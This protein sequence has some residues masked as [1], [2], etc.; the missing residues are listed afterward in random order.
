MAA[1]SR[2][3]RRPDGRA[4]SPPLTASPLL[5]RNLQLLPVGLTQLPNDETFVNRLRQDIEALSSAFA[6]ALLLTI[7]AKA[8]AASL[9]DSTGSTSSS[10][11]GPSLNIPS[12]EGFAVS[13]FSVFVHIWREKGW[14]YVQF[15]FGDHT[16]SKRA[17][18]DAICRV[19]LEGLEPYVTARNRSHAQDPELP[20][21][22]KL[23]NLKDMFKT[24]AIPFALYLFWSTQIHPTSGIGV[25]HC[26]PALERIPIEQDYYD[27]LL[28]LPEVILRHLREE[29]RTKNLSDALTADL[30]EVLCRLVGEPSRNDSHFEA[31][32]PPSLAPSA[33][34]VGKKRRQPWQDD[35]SAE[36]GTA[37]NDSDPVF[38]IIPSSSL[39][40]RL[41]RIWPSVRVMSSQE[42]NKEFGRIG[43]I[44]RISPKD[45]SAT[46]ASGNVDSSSAA[47]GTREA[48]VGLSRGDVVRLKAKQRLAKA[49]MDLS[50]ILDQDNQSAGATHHSSSSEGSAATHPL[51]LA[52]ASTSEE[53]PA[54]PVRY[55]IDTPS[56]IK[57][58]KYTAKMQPWLEQ[59][60]TPIQPSLQRIFKN[61]Q[62]YSEVREKIM[63]SNAPIDDA[64]AAEMA[65][66]HESGT[67][68]GKWILQ[69]FRET[70]KEMQANTEGSTQEDVSGLPNVDDQGTL[71]LDALYRLAAERT[72][73]I[74]VERGEML[75]SARAN[76]SRPG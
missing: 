43:T 2:K 73:T 69:R 3:R 45:G 12:T 44:V 28:D 5:T 34:A 57:S 64:A 68:Y 9:A 11:V 49:N 58:A 27:L 8:N 60:S 10:S 19:L 6:E 72:K 35:V 66:G 18:S 54:Q 65:D 13:P 16:D 46:E 62:R 21:Q 38:D 32:Q 52:S 48:I 50:R 56:W 75:K 33:K 15:A 31:R 14:H 23:M 74:A 55:E 51:T 47:T 24:M 17:I 37:K 67:D 71:T 53:T 61:K 42:A 59:S 20:H 30:V 25:K 22:M 39:A 26:R 7:V 1:G 36:N 63:R 41:P 70:R 40:T 29:E 4:A 76:G